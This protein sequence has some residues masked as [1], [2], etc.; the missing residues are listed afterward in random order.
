[1]AVIFLRK[2]SER[3]PNH[4]TLYLRIKSSSCLTVSEKLKHNAVK[5]PNVNKY[6]NRTRGETSA[7]SY[8]FMTVMS[9]M[10]IN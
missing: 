7:Y 6:L 10:I 5:R 2:V 8:M 9:I 4:K 3:L 1:M